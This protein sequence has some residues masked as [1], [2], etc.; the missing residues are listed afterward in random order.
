MGE[1]GSRIDRGIEHS[2]LQGSGQRT[3]SWPNRDCVPDRGFTLIELLVVIAIIAVLI[4]LLLAGG[5]GSPRGRPAHPMREQSQQLGLAMHN[6]E[7]AMAAC[8]RRKSCSSIRSGAVSWK[9]QWGVTSRI[10]PYL[11]LG[12]DLQLDQLRHQNDRPL[13]TRRPSPRNCGLYLP[14]RNQSSGRSRARTARGRDA[15][16]FGVSDYGW[17]EGDW[18]VYG[19]AITAAAESECLRSQ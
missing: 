16:I 1:S 11:E 5:T 2:G 7:S 17:C 18:Y 3:S 10:T 4:A 13:T 19:G 9:S 6:Y 14:K 8:R 12:P 15:V